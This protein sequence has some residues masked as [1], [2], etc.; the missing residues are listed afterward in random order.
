MFC[1]S[2]ANNV[3]Q[4]DGT[5]CCEMPHRNGYLTRPNGSLSR[6]LGG[7]TVLIQNKAWQCAHW[8]GEYLRLPECTFGETTNLFCR[9]RTKKSKNAEQKSAV[10]P[11]ATLKQSLGFETSLVQAGICF[12]KK[13]CS[14]RR[15][16]QLIEEGR[17]LFQIFISLRFP[18]QVSVLADVDLGD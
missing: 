17:T 18:I 13:R 4:R 15:E 7:N 14:H 5:S 6:P 11:N 9:C 2:V 12:A 10:S 1:F 16:V 3:F 8:F